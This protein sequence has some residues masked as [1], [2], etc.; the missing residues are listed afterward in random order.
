M[1]KEINKLTLLLNNWLLWAA[2]AFVSANNEQITQVGLI[3]ISMCFNNKTS[4]K[5][6]Y[7]ESKTGKEIEN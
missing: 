7:N 6:D 3:S 1:S 2:K 5:S 4:Q